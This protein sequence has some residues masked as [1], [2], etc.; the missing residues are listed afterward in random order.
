MPLDQRSRPSLTEPRPPDVHLRHRAGRAEQLL[1]HSNTERTWSLAS[2]CAGVEPWLAIA[3]PL[4]PEGVLLAG[5]WQAQTGRGNSYRGA[6]VA[7]VVGDAE[8]P[9]AVTR[10]GISSV[11]VGRLAEVGAHGMT[12]DADVSATLLSE[13]SE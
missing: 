2:W 5:V 4:D 9:R 3:Q 12:V 6:S 7:V 13:R 10:L 8:L 11:R 1:E